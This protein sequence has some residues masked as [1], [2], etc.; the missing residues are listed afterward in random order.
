[1]EE[2]DEQDIGGKMIEHGRN[3]QTSV[4]RVTGGGQT[5]VTRVTG[6]MQS[7]V[8]GGDDWRKWEDKNKIPFVSLF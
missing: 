5:G 1:M 7:G 6:G 8:T 2:A 3:R 4:T